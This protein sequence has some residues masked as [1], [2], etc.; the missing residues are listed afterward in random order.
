MTT[1]PNNTKQ[2]GIR[3]ITTNATLAQYF[4]LVKKSQSQLQRLSNNFR[5]NFLEAQTQLEPNALAFAM[6]WFAQN[7]STQHTHDA[8][9]Q[10]EII[11]LLQCF[12]KQNT[13]TQ[14]LFSNQFNRI[15]DAEK[16]LAQWLRNTDDNNLTQKEKLEQFREICG[17]ES[18]QPE[19]AT[20]P[21]P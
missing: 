5:D 20:T 18:T 14:T 4:S 2:T 8:H 6:F 12:Y 21:A 16:K 9:K 19:P 17:V 10:H 15:D 11:H 7:T 1:K 3:A 13:P